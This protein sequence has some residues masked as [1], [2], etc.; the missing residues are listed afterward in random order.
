[1]TI[2]LNSLLARRVS[3]EVAAASVVEDDVAH[4]VLDPDN[5]LGVLDPVRS[6]DLGDAMPLLAGVEPEHWILALPR[7]GVPGSV[8]GPRELTEAAVDTGEAVL[9]AS[10]GVALVPYRVGRAV[11][12][13]VFRANRPGSPP[14]RYEAERT[15][16]EAVLSAAQALAQLDVAAGVRPRLTV[17]AGLAPGYSSRQQ[18]TAER[19]AR[20]LV[21]CDT[22]L[23]DDGGSISAFEADARARQLRTVRD[24]C[25][26][27]LCAAV[28][29]IDAP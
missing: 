25:I 6:T 17:P 28:S 10:S 5:V 15:L 4:H 21:A 18:A 27:A 23:L 29:W 22:A 26:G 19:A 14:T 20:L 9:A 12:W 3:A 13:R 11:Q 16:S 8:R 7:P 24:A 2:Y 1:M